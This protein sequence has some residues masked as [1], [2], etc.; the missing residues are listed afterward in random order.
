M[1][2]KHFYYFTNGWISTVPKMTNLCFCWG[3]CETTSSTLRHLGAHFE[4]H[5]TTP[6]KVQCSGT[7]PPWWRWA[8]FPV[9]FLKFVVKQLYGY[10]E[11][12]L[13]HI[14]LIKDICYISRNIEL[15][16][17]WGRNLSRESWNQ[18]WLSCLMFQTIPQDLIINPDSQ[19]GLKS[20]ALI[21]YFSKMFC[22]IFTFHLGVSNE[23]LTKVMN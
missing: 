22:V 17:H 16:L 15:G 8:G 11:L 9:C 21:L 20:V 12:Y 13:N 6:H 4:S 19:M 2:S 10:Y 1:N 18:L 7:G 3:L 14:L 23:T 5:Y